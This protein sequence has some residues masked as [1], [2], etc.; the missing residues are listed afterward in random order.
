MDLNSASSDPLPDRPGV[1][2][3]TVAEFPLLFISLNVLSSALN[4]P[5]LSATR[6]DFEILLHLTLLWASSGS[7]DPR[8]RGDLTRSDITPS[9]MANFARN[10]QSSLPVMLV[11]EKPSHSS[12][13]LSQLTN[14][15]DGIRGSPERGNPLT[16]GHMGWLKQAGICMNIKM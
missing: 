2:S 6:F 4:N 9:Y 1:P 14:S 5:V 16:S 7:S 3:G 12:T 8:E 11:I 13:Q 10:L 15:T